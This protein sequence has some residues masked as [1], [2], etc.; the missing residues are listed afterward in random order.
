M[1]MASQF[2]SLYGPFVIMFSLP[3]TFIGAILG[4]LVTHRTINMNSIIGM[5]MLVG[6]VV[7]NAIVLVDYT[8]QLRRSGMPLFDALIEAGKVRLRPILMTTGTTVLA[9][10]PLV[11]GF[12]EGAETQASMATVVAFGLTL[13]TMVTL[14][15]VPV[16]FTLM[17][18][19]FT[20]I[21]RRFKRTP[22]TGEPTGTT[23]SL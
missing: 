20:R 3:P 21:K 7:N 16:V 2:E 22:G 14:V 23:V 19:F 5:I 12:G 17:D 9:M 4:L 15:L 18:G 6:I 10:L 8:N 11:I 13:S 1:V